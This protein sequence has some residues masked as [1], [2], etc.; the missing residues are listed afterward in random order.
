MCICNG[1]VVSFRGS[2]R[3]TVDTLGAFAEEVV[4][5][6]GAPMHLILG[7]VGDGRGCVCV[8]VLSCSPTHL[9]VW[10]RVSLLCS[11]GRK[12]IPLQGHTHT[13]TLFLFCILL[14]KKSKQNVREIVFMA[15]MFTCLSMKGQIIN[16]TWRAV[17]TTA[18]LS[19]VSVSVV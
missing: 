18:H 4:V 19:V 8:Y 6:V 2:I 9:S 16:K 3:C 7:L 5:V 15:C 11:S 17:Y 13:H 1:S 14:L 10:G 12:G